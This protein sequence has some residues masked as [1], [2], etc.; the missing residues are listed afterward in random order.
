LTQGFVAQIRLGQLN[1]CRSGS[2][3]G[4]TGS[5]DVPHYHWKAYNEVL[6]AR[7]SLLIWLDP[8]MNW[9]CQLSGRW[10]HSQAFRYKAIKFCLSIKC[11]FNLP[12][13]QAM[14][15]TQSLLS[16]AGLDWSVLD[17]NTVSRRHE[18][19]Q[20]TIGAMPTTTGL[21]LLV[22]STGIK[23]LGGGEWKTKK[24]GARCISG[25]MRPRSRSGPW[26]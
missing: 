9:H 18:T 14:D 10:G 24:H 17:Y 4:E 8:K 5:S 1:P 20:V 16:L 19:L 22:D 26:R 25:S 23:M 3:S 15:M 6:K 2:L 12:L 13:S 11:F 7:G 21:H